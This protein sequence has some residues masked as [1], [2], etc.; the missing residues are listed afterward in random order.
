MGYIDVDITSGNVSYTPNDDKAIRV[1]T[2]NTPKRKDKNT[3]ATPYSHSEAVADYQQTRNFSHIGMQ[4]PIE[5][6]NL[7]LNWAYFQKLCHHE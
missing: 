7:T 1:K 4:H 5:V 2:L 3:G 6:K